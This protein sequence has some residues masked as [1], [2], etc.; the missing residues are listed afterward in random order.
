MQ[1]IKARVKAVSADQRGVIAGLHDAP[2]LHDDN[3]VRVLDGREPMG[4]Y[5]RCARDADQAVL[6]GGTI[7]TT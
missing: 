4:D 5:Q 7:A 6:P 3:A 2:R 1:S